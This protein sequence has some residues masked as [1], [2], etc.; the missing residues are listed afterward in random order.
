VA[1]DEKESSSPAKLPNAGGI[2]DETDPLAPLTA[3]TRDAGKGILAALLG[4]ENEIVR[5]DASAAPVA[6]SQHIRLRVL[7]V[8]V[9]PV[10]A[11]TLTLVIGTAQYPFDGA[12]RALQPFPFPLVIERGSDMSC[13]GADGRIYL[14]GAPE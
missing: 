8:I 1:G 3:A 2:G 7:T 11:G 6:Q 10:T 13:V 14:I 9:N 4:V 5:L 12:A